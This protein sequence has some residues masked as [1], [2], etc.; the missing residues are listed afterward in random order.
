MVSLG[1]QGGVEIL[2]LDLPFLLFLVP[3]LGRVEMGGEG[4]IMCK[5]SNF[6]TLFTRSIKGTS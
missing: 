3:F 1:E 2:L 4:G 6:L 5:V